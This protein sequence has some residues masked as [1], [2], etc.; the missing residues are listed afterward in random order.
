[1]FRFLVLILVSMPVFS[2]DSIP[3]IPWGEKGTVAPSFY[4]DSGYLNFILISNGG[5]G[6]QRVYFST[7]SGEGSYC[8]TEHQNYE[9]SDNQIWRIAGQNI[10]MQVYCEPDGKGDLF[11]TAVARNLKGNE[12][13]VNNFK[14]STTDITVVH[15]NGHTVEVSTQGFTKAWSNSGGDAL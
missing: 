15:D 2:E 5:D 14:K 13:I 7:L 9:N 12:F 3:T 8:T 4:N 10:T 11:Q 1:M 6:K